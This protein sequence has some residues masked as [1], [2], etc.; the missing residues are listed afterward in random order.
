MRVIKEPIAAAPTV[1]RHYPF[2]KLAGRYDAWF[3]SPRGRK[4]F[5]AEAQTLRDLIEEMPRPWLEVGVGTGRF[6]QALG[7][8]D[9]ID[10][11]LEVLKIAGQRNIKIWLGRGEDLPF[12]ESSYGMVLMIVTICFLSN[13]EKALCEASRVLRDDGHLLLGLVPKD[14]PW[15]NSY[16]N[17]AHKGHP[18]YSAAIFYTCRDTIEMAAAAGFDLERSRSCLFEPPDTEVNAYSNSQDG[19]VAGSG[20]VGMRFK[21]GH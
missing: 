9:G 14:S 10:P 1:L 12:T 8:D 21:K 15:G 3:D 2:E 7:V 6:G 5:A 18:F 13:P 11:S 16:A 20:F 19:I 17:K 4:I